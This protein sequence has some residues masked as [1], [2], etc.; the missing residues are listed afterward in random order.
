LNIRIKH[1]QTEMDLDFCCRLCVLL[2]TCRH[3]SHNYS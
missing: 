1:S 2:S 3:L